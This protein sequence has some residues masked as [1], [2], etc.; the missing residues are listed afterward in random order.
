MS[1]VI[2]RFNRNLRLA[3]NPPLYHALKTGAQLIPI[4]I[5]HTQNR[6]WSPGAASRSWLHHS[7]M[8]LEQSLRACGNRLYIFTGETEAV[9]LNVIQQS[10]ASAVYGCQH[11]EPTLTQEDDNLRDSL[12][13]IG[14]KLHLYNAS[15]LFSPTEILNRQGQPYKVFTPY[16]R[17]CIT[18]GL[19]SHEL[20][21]PQRLPAYDRPLTSLKL[22]QLKLLPA[23][24]WDHSFYEHWRPGEAGALQQLNE[25]HA[26]GLQTYSQLRD[27]PGDNGTSRLSPHLHFGEISPRTVLARLQETRQ[28]GRDA[29][30]RQLLWRDF[31]HAVLYHFPHTC[32]QPF[33]EKF[34]RFP[35]RPT[36]SQAIQA[37]QT[38]RTG[39]PI[40]DAGMRQLWHMGWLHNRV[41]MIV[42]S[43]LT[44]N[45]LQHWR[46]GA[47]W[48]WDTLVDADLAQNS[49]NWQWVAGSGVDAAPYFRIFNPVSQGGKFD[50]RGTYL[51]QWVPELASLDLRYRHRP[52]EA[53]ASVLE[54]A[55]IILGENY[56]LPI[57]D[58]RQSRQRA[59]EAFHQARH[60]SHNDTDR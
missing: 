58:L 17:A 44:K 3:D 26:A 41:R 60:L 2:V 15:L 11:Y 50:P 13:T 10:G 55:G 40:V 47:E 57:V 14:V 5:H 45:L 54:R 49:M 22:D 21:A 34:I 18:Q 51:D 30:I 59:L 8:A 33:N 37:W 38:G 19:I 46:H 53:K 36:D 48:F 25:F 42:A 1:P 29:V 23:I 28:P 20:P 31:A 6:V 27:I 9:I 16:Y 32:Q 43:F 24:S 39:I 56:P 4:Y 7:L 52:W 35:W 12:N